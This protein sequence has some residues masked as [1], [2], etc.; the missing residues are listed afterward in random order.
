MT[1]LSYSNLPVG[2]RR[3]VSGDLVQLGVEV[4]GAFVV[5]ANLKTGGFDE[6]LAEAKAKAD[7]AA[8]DQPANQ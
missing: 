3:T 7:A 6:D 8:T 5:F 1:E 4:D 2:L